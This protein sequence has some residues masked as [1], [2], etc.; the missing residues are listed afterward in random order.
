[1]KKEWWKQ[2]I[3][4]RVA[5]LDYYFKKELIKQCVL[6]LKVYTHIP[7]EVDDIYNSMLYEVAKEIRWYKEN[8]DIKAYIGRKSKNLAKNFCRQYISQKYMVMNKY[9]QITEDITGQEQKIELLDFSKLSYKENKI[10]KL[11]YVEDK[12]KK[13]VAESL[14][15][16][17]KKLDTIIIKIREKL[18]F[19][20]V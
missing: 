13:S 2:S 18:L 6:V 20:C 8:L 4:K 10:F 11:L 12:T 16:P 9:V 14:S 17:R 5:F 15:I 1:M 19:N 7:V 3:S